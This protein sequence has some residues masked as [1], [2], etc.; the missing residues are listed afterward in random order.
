MTTSNMKAYIRCGTDL[1]L[2]KKFRTMQWFLLMKYKY[3]LGFCIA[4]W[5]GLN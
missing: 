5:F 4:F 1:A 3:I 2:N